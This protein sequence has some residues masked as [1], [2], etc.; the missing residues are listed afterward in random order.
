MVSDQFG[1]PSICASGPVARGQILLSSIFNTFISSG[2]LN[3]DFEF[4]STRT[5]H[6]VI[7]RKLKNNIPNTWE[8]CERP[9]R[10][11]EGVRGLSDSSM[12]GRFRVIAV[13]RKGA[14]IMSLIWGREKLKCRK[15]KFEANII[16]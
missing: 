10:L 12:A 11:E 8:R 14:E 9:R 13:S 5:K 2:L 3:Q 4:L 7:H 1:L 16:I 15:M 6:T